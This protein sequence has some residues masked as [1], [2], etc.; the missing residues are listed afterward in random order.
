MNLIEEYKAIYHK[1]RKAFAQML[2]ERLILFAVNIIKLSAK[3]PNDPE[4]IVVKTELTKAGTSVGAIYR[5][6]NIARSRLDFGDKIKLCENESGRLVYWLTI[7]SHL[8]WI[9]PE[10]IAEEIQEAN[11]FFS[12]F[13][14]MGKTINESVKK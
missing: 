8:K 2:E 11:N 5:Q 6:A 1:D 9:L 10:E 4:G 14:T 13:K 12:L 7:I 3:L